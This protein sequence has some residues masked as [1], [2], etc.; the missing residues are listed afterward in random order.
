MAVAAEAVAGAALLEHRGGFARRW[1]RTPSFVAGLAII[2]TLIL[3]AILA[4]LITAHDPTRQDLQHTLQPP[5]G[6]HLLGTDDLGR[7]V[8]ARLVFGARTDLRVAFLAVLFPF[9][10]DTTLGLLAGY[11]GGFLDTVVNRLVSVVVAFPS[12]VLII[13]LVFALGPGTRNIYIA[14]TIVG[15][16]SYTRIVRAE[17]IGAKRREYVLAA[18]AGGLSTPRILVSGDPRLILC[19][20]P[21]TAL[22]VTIQDQILRLLAS[23]RERLGVALVFVSHD[24]T[25]IA[26]TCQRVAVMYGGQVVETGSVA[27]VFREPSHPYTLSLLRSVPDYDAVRERLATIPGQPPDL[28]DPPSGCPFHPR[29]AFAHDDCRSGDFPLRPVDLPG[30]ETACIHPEACAEDIAREPVIARA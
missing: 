7:D 22:D 16:V 25:V 8:W 29:F 6:G 13:A 10:I 19:D 4:P 26:Q 24:L 18:R 11:F 21:T 2:G 14:I 15:W 28:A 17:V 30:R 1:Y 27:A 12:Y 20:E 9:V 3:M 23:L 5:G